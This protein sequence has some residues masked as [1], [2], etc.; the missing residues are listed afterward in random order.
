M[1]TTTKCDLCK[2]YW[3]AF[4]YIKLNEKVYAVCANCK[5]EN[6]QAVGAK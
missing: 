1:A 4:F 6:A 5:R 3:A 2:R